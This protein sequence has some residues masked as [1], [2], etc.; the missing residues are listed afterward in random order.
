MGFE[1]ITGH[2]KIIKYIQTAIKQE[3]LGHAYI[4]EGQAGVGKGIIALEFIKA[5]NCKNNINNGCDKCSSCMK[6]NSDN[7]PDINVLEPQGKSI[8]NKQIEE[9][10]REILLRPYESN[11]KAFI[12]QQAD[13]MTTSAQNRILKILEEPPEYGIIIFISENSGHLLPTVK[14]RCQL[15]K[16]NRIS[17]VEIEKYLVEHYEIKEE[18]AKIL[19]AF[20]G[21]SLSKAISL[22]TSDEFKNRR[23]IMIDIVDE[24]LRGDKLKLIDYISF[25][26]SN[27]DIIWEILDFII[28]WF[29]D[30]LLL[31]EISSYKY[32]F[33]LDK[34]NTLKI[35]ANNIQYDKIIKSI[36]IIEDTK[37][38]I[39]ANANFGLCIETM[40]LN[41]QEV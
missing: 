34:I 1:K 21:G 9:F 35:H 4:F 5:I 14:S 18:D 39:N 19:S 10:Q 31:K 15:L 38:S 17:D 12:I 7:H 36:A 24:V 28:I 23:E 11:K 27:K 13:T 8:K 16:F 30:M 41:L 33:N 22:H 40:L 37:K 2:D 25:F 20:S 32:L 3:K 6:I 29:R 26:E